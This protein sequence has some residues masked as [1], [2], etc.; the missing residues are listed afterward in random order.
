M[1]SVQM[2]MINFGIAHSPKFA[3]QIFFC[4]SKDLNISW[5]GFLKLLKEYQGSC[6]I[7]SFL[8]SIQRHIEEEFNLPL[9][10][11]VN[12]FSKFANTGCLAANISGDS[13][14]SIYNSCAPK[15]LV[16]K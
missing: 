16:C 14:M 10:Y 9:Y 11:A 4:T 2:V 3:E 1:I 5:Q 15:N 6:Q 12:P 13:S 8:Y 7:S